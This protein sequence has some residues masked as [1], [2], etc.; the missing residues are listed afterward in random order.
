MTEGVQTFN[1]LLRQRYR[2]KLG[3]LQNLIK[4]RDL[5]ANRDDSYSRLLTF[6]RI[7]MAFIGELMLLLEPL[8][9][10]Y[11]IYVCWLLATPSMI[12]GA[13]MTITLYLLLNIW[14][15]EHM[16]VAKKVRMSLITPIMYFVF[17]IMNIVQLVAIIRC[18]INHHQTL[19]RTQVSSSWI[20]PKR[21]GDQQVQFS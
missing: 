1:A 6:Y 5:I 3:S 21:A 12:I 15:D 18:L 17:Y 11:V 2:W 13:Y 8:A 4:H 20:S 9:I 14:P 16:D 19:G 7:P 10:A